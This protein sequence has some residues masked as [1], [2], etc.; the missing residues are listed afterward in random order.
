MAWITQKGSGFLVRWR[1]ERKRTRSRYFKDRADA[2]AE[3][4]RHESSALQKA[5][6]SGPRVGDYSPGVYFDKERMGW[7]WPDG[8][9]FVQPDSIGADEARETEYA[10][11]NY[12]RSIIDQDKELRLSSRETYLHSLKNH[13]ADTP[14][15]RADIRVCS[16]ET[17]KDFWAKLDVGVGALRNVYLLLAK[18][19]NCA[20]REALIDVSPLKRSGIKSP[21]KSRRAEV[22]PL[23][24]AEV[25]R[26][27]DAACFP[28]DRLAILLMA[29]AGLRAGEVGGLRV[30]DVDFE[31]CRISVRQQ[32]VQ[33]HREK[34]ITPLKT[35][36]ARRTLDVARGIMDELKAF[37]EAEP[38]TPDGR[39]FHGVD[40]NLWAHSKINRQVHKAASAAGLRPVHSHMLRHTA[41]S[42]LIDDGANPKAIQAFVGHANITETLQ[43]YGH[44]FDFGGRALAESMERRR[45]RYR[46]AS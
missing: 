35:K 4:A 44:L 27:A 12:L 46:N 22:I 20:V 9:R 26:L 30:Q 18:A 42:L 45:E 19:F 28:R 17:V 24:V 43:T 40:G 36:S 8:K 31:R 38:P 32:V 1:D 15:G 11:A 33:T 29:Y 34:R 6:Q 2:E 14:L 41:V 5:V 25:E 37:T 23:T 3:K 16:V 21:A 13:I 39:I 10:V 7:F